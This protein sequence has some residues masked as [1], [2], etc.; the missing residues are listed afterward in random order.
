[1]DKSTHYFSRGPEFGSQHLSVLGR[2]QPPM[3][4]PPGDPMA[5]L[6]FVGG[7]AHTHTHS[8]QTHTHIHKFFKNVFKIIAETS[9]YPRKEM[10]I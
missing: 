4:A 7:H 9:V 5:S 2:S 1:M 8:I 10:A 6:A 3:I